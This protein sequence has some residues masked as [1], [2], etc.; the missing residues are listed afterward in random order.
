LEELLALLPEELEIDEDEMRAALRLL[1]SFDPP[2][3]GARDL[4]ECLALQLQ[5]ESESG[6][7]E[8]W[9]IQ[10]AHRIC[11]AHLE[12]LAAR[13]YLRL[14]RALRVDEEKIRLA[15]DLIRKL[16]PFPASGFAQDTASYITP[17]VSV[18]KIR[19]RWTALLNQDVM[20]QLRVNEMYAQILQ[21][22]RGSGLSG[23]LQEARWLIRNVHQRFDTILRV[24]QAIVERQ[25]A[26]F[27]H[28]EVAMRPLILR[29]IADVLGLHESTISRVTT[30]KY[31]ST[32][33]G[34][35]ELKFFF[36]SHVATESG[37]AA[38]STAIRALIKQLIAQEDQTNPISDSRIADLLGEKGIV[39][40]RRT[41]AKYREA[42]RIPSVAQRKAA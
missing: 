20:P 26:F 23:Q 28:G 35:Y 41:V 22:Q 38:S 34:T 33:F 1:Q 12:L 3:V 10:L 5:I 7:Q 11:E 15:H 37:G 24:S 36:G 4:K 6:Q 17:D 25:K 21:K 14:R 16:N 30:A 2:G 13:E 39:V 40:A 31:M 29:E 18:R 27:Q 42:L 32:P 8:H 19:G 9:L